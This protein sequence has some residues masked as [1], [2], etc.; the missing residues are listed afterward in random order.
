MPNALDSYIRTVLREDEATAMNI[1]A[2]RC[3]LL[4]DNAVRA[5][6]VGNSGEIIAWCERHPHLWRYRK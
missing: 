5:E 4:S 2:E 3:H 6:D 1:L